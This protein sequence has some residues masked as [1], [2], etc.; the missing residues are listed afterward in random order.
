LVHRK[1]RRH[2]PRGRLVSAQRAHLFE[3]ALVVDEPTDEAVAVARGAAEPGLPGGAD[4]QRNARFLYGERRDA[5]VL[6]REALAG[7]G[8]GLA[9]PQPADDLQDLVGDR[10]ALLAVEAVRGG[11]SGEV[12]DAERELG[13]T[14]R[15]E[16]EHRHVLGEAHRVI[17]RGEADTGRDAHGLG[18]GGHRSA[19]HQR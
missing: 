12:A 17:V 11:F 3:I 5:R 14:V 9:F 1:P 16:V 6:D 13:A 18:A 8:D 10:S 15:D 2:E 7:E 4:E 19:D